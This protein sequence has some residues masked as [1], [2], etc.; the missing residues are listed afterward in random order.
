MHPCGREDVANNDVLVREACQSHQ[1]D[2]LS[3]GA[4]AA[5]KGFSKIKD[6]AVYLVGK[7]S[8][9]KDALALFCSSVHTVLSVHIVYFIEVTAAFS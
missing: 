9:L 7:G 3:V 5:D 6:Q 4:K 8:S 2:I 1:Q